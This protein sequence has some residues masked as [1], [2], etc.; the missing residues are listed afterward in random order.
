MQVALIQFREVGK[1]YYFSYD[2]NLN[3]K[4]LDTVVVETSVGLEIGKI[5]QIKDEKDLEIIEALKPVIRIATKED[6]EEKKQNEQ[7]EKD[8]VATTRKIALDLDLDM[9]VLDAE[10]TLDKSKVTIYFE[11]EN[12]VDFREL[13][14]RLSTVY[15]TRI[16]LR[17]IGPRD[18]AKKV[19]G[20]G[21]C[22]LVLCCSSFIGEFDPVTIKMAKNQNL[23][24]NPKKIS[25]VCGKLLCCLKYE[26]EVY[27]ELRELLPD[28]NDKV[29][30][31]HG[32][33]KVLDVNYLGKKLKVK[34][35][36]DDELSMGWI[37]SSNIKEIKTNA[38]DKN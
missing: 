15:Q 23:T 12:R 16:E 18:V 9:K 7:G 21:P 29:M 25:G 26:D 34:Y 3:L 2:E 36:E 35:L 10:Y 17:Q 19:G 33:A 1:K 38:S 14:K 27:T 24:L 22:G 32:L 20:I 13:V 4:V 8:V 6:I 37:S 28:I 30:T 5:Y 31:E 11:S